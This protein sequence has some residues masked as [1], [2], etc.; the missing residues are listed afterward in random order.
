VEEKNKKDNGR[1]EFINEIKIL[2]GNAKK[3]LE[4]VNNYKNKESREKEKIDNARNFKAIFL[5]SL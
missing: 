3:A 5:R 2:G 4:I 1:E